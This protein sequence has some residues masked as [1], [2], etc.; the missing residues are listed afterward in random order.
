MVDSIGR[1]G[2]SPWLLAHDEAKNSEAL[3]RIALAKSRIQSI[4]DQHV[5]AH[6]KTLE[7][8][9]A[10][11]GPSD[12]RVDPHLIGLAIKDLLENN[13]LRAINHASTGNTRWY[14]NLGT[15]D[16]K[17]APK[18]D[19]LAPLYQQI[20][21]NGFG[22]LL[23]DALEVVVFKCLLDRYKTSARYPFQGSFLLDEPKNA[24]GRYIKIEPPKNI[25]V[26][27][28]TKEADFLQYGYDEGPLCIECKNYR[29]WLY[30]NDGMIKNLILKSY[31]LNAIPTIIHRRIHYT[32]LSN[33]FEPSGIMAHESYY[34]YYPADKMDLASVAKDKNKLGFSDITHDEE[35]HARTKKFIDTV[36]PKI[37]GPM[38]KKWIMNKEH[39]YQYALGQINLAQL[40]TRIGSPAGGK[41]RDI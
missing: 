40:Y 34:Q 26:H 9:I 22:N 24:S 17:A 31:E 8:K 28:T 41:W 25:A 11:Q 39:L 35:P 6:Q 3:E 12:K 10:D 14:A 13:R 7:Q 1:G 36:I 37:I 5:V 30:P 20:T 23:G 4:L 29:E 21:G 15:T 33:L 19:E 18:L 32:T 27:A 38:S 2:F 16:S